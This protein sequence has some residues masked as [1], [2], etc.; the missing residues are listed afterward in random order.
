MGRPRSRFE[1]RPLPELVELIRQR[2][3]RVGKCLE[4][5][6]ARTSAGYGQVWDGFRNL[7]THRVMCEAAHGPAPSPRHEA[8]HDCDNPPCSEPAHLLWGTHGDNLGDMAS[9]GR[10]PMGGAVLTAADIPTIRR[11]AAAGESDIAI[12]ADYAVTRTAIHHIRRRTT[13]KAIP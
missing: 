11:R 1:P 10:G 5:G 2:S 9:K 6:R 12:A 8:L 7:Y 4:Y 3:V 13:W